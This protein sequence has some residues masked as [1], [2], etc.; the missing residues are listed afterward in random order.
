MEKRIAIM[1]DG[2]NVSSDYIEHIIKEASKYG[3]ILISRLYGNIEKLSKTWKK[4]AVDYAIKMMHQYKVATSK[5]AADMAMALDALEFKYQDKIDVFFIVSSDSDFT[6]LATKLK[7]LGAYVVG[8]G[9]EEKTKAFK[10][11]YSEFKYFEYFEIEEKTNEEVNNNNNEEEV[12]YVEENNKIKK[13]K[14]V[15]NKDKEEKSKIN[16]VVELKKTI[17]NII[18]E[19]GENNKIMLSKVGSILIN[20]FS[21]FDSRKYGFTS[22][23]PLVENLGFK[24]TNESTTTYIW[25]KSEISIDEVKKHINNFLKEEKSREISSLKRYLLEKIDNFNTNDFGFSRM[26]RMLKNLD[27]NVDKGLFDGKKS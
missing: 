23:S 1:I 6:P 25:Y 7:E 14:N 19:N 8:I 20:Q 12:E 26:S 27:Y 15:K 21:D 5:N 11:A 16:K 13:G 24:L 4:K 18:L 9:E 10:S 22:L 2:E 3:S 17:Q